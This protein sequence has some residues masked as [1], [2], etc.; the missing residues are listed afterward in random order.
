MQ[1]PQNQRIF[2]M[3]VSLSMQTS[4]DLFVEGHSLRSWLAVEFSVL[5][6]TVVRRVSLHVV[7]IK[8]AKYNCATCWLCQI[9]TGRQQWFRQALM[10]R[11]NSY[12]ESCKVSQKSNGPALL[13]ICDGSH[14]PSILKWWGKITWA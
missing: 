14:F 2:G 1:Y 7:N 12:S 10:M 13:S 3:K 11:N 6:N 5:L 9:N 8:L 4:R